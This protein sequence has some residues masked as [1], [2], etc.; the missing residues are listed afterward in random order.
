MKIRKFKRE[1][2]KRKPWALQYR[3]PDGSR[4]TLTFA[5]KA[6]RDREAEKLEGNLKQ[7]GT[8]LASVAMDEW[9][10]WCEL[11]SLM[12][13]TPVRAAVEY[14]LGHHTAGAPVDFQEA[15]ER[16]LDDQRR[17]GY[18]TD[19]IRHLRTA[20][21][22]LGDIDPDPFAMPPERLVEWFDRANFVAET[23]RN[24]RKY[25]R[26]FFNY[27]EEHG[28]SAGNPANRVKLPRFVRG[29][30][31]ILSLDQTGVLFA[32]SWAHDQ[33][34]TARMALE[35]F[36]GVRASEAG[37]LRYEDIDFVAR[38]IMLRTLPGTR[39]KRRQYIEGMP[40]TIWSYLEAVS[41]EDFAMEGSQYMHRKS[42]C[43]LV[44]GIQMPKNALRHS[45]VTYLCAWKQSA[46]L[47][48][49]II[50]HRKASSILFEHY[51]GVATQ[52]EGRQY[53][54]DNFFKTV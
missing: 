14:Y 2:R 52:E 47:A 17:Q 31:G 18:S 7:H 12:G 15:R 34:A 38:G 39:H 44:S 8:S 53:F 1:D 23:K 42:Q 9:R 24:Y 36:A 3:R 37:R 30:P 54:E 35:A 28:I 25:F 6:E 41:K 33:G 51:K 16:Y 5:T 29:E 49:L 26:A 27:C 32:K 4:P 22:V 40:G 19:H 11:K 45:F 13:D 10:T 43:V 48:A 20:L 21:K 46:D 50:G